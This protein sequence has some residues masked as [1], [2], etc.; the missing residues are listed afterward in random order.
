MSARTCAPPSSS[1]VAP[2]KFASCQM[3]L[4][5][6][7]PFLFSID[8]EEY[9]PAVPGRSFR[10]TPLPALVD[11]YLELLRGR[12]HAT[13]FVVG[14][15]ARKFPHVLE[16]IATEGHELAC[17]GNR[18]LTLDRFSPREFAADLRANRA[19]IEQVYRQP[20]R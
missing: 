18:H 2:P 8:L 7:P 13:F 14:D 3:S 5:P 17:H 16:R 20:I 15:V 12:G 4:S 19:A 1:I 6:V 10:A 9:Y 11:R